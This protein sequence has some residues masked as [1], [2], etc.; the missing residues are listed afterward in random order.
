MLATT[1]IA[2]LSIRMNAFV[3]GFFLAI[4]LLAVGTVSVVGLTH[5][6]QTLSILFVAQTGAA[7]NALSPISLVLLLAGVSIS[8]F[9]YNGDDTPRF[10]SEETTAPLRVL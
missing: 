6:H 2:I 10:S 5:I 3:T 8:I 7:H 4:E 9:S 1:L